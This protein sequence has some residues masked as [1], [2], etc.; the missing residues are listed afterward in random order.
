ML[1][2]A[3]VKIIQENCFKSDCSK[4]QLQ[5]YS[6]QISPQVGN[7][8]TDRCNT[9]VAK[10]KMRVLKMLQGFSTQLQREDPMTQVGIHHVGG[11]MILAISNNQTYFASY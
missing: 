4:L 10:L 6:M 1:Q 11:G 2:R 3:D 8:K 5:M 9:S 7:Y